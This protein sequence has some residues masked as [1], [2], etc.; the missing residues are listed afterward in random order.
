[1][2]SNPAAHQPAEETA[3]SIRGVS[4]KPLRLQ[5][6]ATFGSIEHCLCGLDLVIG[7]RGRWFDV[8][9][10]CVLDVDEIVEPIPELHALVG[11]RR[12]RRGR[13]GGRDYLRRLA[14]GR[15]GRGP[16]R[17]GIPAEINV[18]GAPETPKSSDIPRCLSHRTVSPSRRELREQR[19]LAIVKA[20]RCK[21]A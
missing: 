14:I 3:R 18:L 8:D 7:A 19:A 15:C 17:P 11:F 20:I 4:C 6:K 12:P 10:D 2:W 21:P 13:I 9:N 16:V 1:M 5:T